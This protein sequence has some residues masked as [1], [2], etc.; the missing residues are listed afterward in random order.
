[1]SIKYEEIENE[2]HTINLATIYCDRTGKKMIEIIIEESDKKNTVQAKWEGDSMP[3]SGKH[4]VVGDIYCSQIESPTQKT[5]I[6]KVIN[7]ETNGVLNYKVL[8]KSI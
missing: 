2:D 7:D 6:V 8:V 3:S 4:E 5:S 1:M